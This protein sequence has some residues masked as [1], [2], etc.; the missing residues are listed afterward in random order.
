MENEVAVIHQY[1]VSLVV[2]LHA[3]RKFARVLQL[4]VDFV[5]NRMSLPWI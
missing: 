2:S 5:A 4:F 1:P 3:D